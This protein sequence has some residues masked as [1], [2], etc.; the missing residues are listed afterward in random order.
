LKAGGVPIYEEHLE[1]VLASA[2]NA[3]RISYKSDTGEAIR[4]ATRSLF[5]WDSAREDGSADLSA[6]DHVAQKIAAEAQSSKLVVEKSTVPARTGVELRRALAAYSE[7]ATFRSA[8]FR[9][10]NFCAKERRFLIFFIRTASWLAWTSIL[11]RKDAGDIRAD[12]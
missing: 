1:E 11:R 5:A 9:I 6:I 7:A 12:S 2:R 8:L 4:F 10:R 3:G